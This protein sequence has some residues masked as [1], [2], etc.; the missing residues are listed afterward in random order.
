[1]PATFEAVNVPAGAAKVTLML[2]DSSLTAA[3]ENTKLPAKSSKRE[4]LAGIVKDGAVL[5]MM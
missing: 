4:K 5:S 3:L 2:D 1:M